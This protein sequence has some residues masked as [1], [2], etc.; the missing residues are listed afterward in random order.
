[1]KC[2]HGMFYI[3]KNIE[4]RIDVFNKIT[5]SYV[6]ET[7][8]NDFVDVFDGVKSFNDLLFTYDMDI[9]DKSKNYLEFRSKFENGNVKA[10]DYI[11]ECSKFLSMDYFKNKYYRHLFKFHKNIHQMKST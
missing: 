10:F 4:K 2:E 1:M 3:Q 9:N 5:F 8:I 6:C 11:L 7:M